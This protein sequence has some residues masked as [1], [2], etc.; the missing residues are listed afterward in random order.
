[1]NRV[2]GYLS[3]KMVLEKWIAP[4]DYYRTWWNIEKYYDT[5]I[6]LPYINNEG[7]TKDSNYKDRLTNVKKFGLWK[8]DQDLTVKPRE[9]EWFGVWD[10]KANDI[11]MKEQDMYKEDW[12][13]LKTLDEAGKLH[14]MAFEGDHLRPKERGY[15]T[16]KVLPYLAPDEDDH[17][18]NIR[19]PEAA[20]YV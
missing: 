18:S 12:I 16:N 5:S 6:L 11:P 14:I 2:L 7:P 17:K 15:L 4:A 19:V 8:W 3:H 10:D 1:M 13:G 20:L 9:S